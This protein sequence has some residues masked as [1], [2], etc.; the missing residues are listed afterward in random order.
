[1]NFA[2]EWPRARMSDSAVEEYVRQGERSQRRWASAKF[3]SILAAC[4]LVG[5]I[6]IYVALNRVEA[7]DDRVLAAIRASGLRTPKLGGAV[8]AA[9]A[10]SESSRHFTATNATGARVEGTVCCGLTGVGKGCTIRWG[11]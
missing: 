9:C 10:E 11:R 5:A 8:T 1:M 2:L 4:V 3:V 7:G 6:G